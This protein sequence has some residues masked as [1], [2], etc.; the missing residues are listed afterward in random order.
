MFIFGLYVNLYT[1]THSPF[2]T[3][4]DQRFS[5]NCS[6]YLAYTYWFLDFDKTFLAYE[7]VA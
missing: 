5:F 1:H 6:E 4:I 7:S 2:Y 3:I